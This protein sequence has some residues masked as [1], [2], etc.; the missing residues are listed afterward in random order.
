MAYKV[1][2][3]FWADGLKARNVDVK[4][5]EWEDRGT[6]GISGRFWLSG[7]LH[8][9]PKGYIWTMKTP[10]KVFL[11]VAEHAH[12]GTIVFNT[13]ND[14]GI[15]HMVE[16]AIS[17]YDMDTK[18]VKLLGKLDFV[19]YGDRRRASIDK[20]SGK[21][22]KATL[23]SAVRDLERLIAKAKHSGDFEY[24]LEVI[25]ADGTPRKSLMLL[26]GDEDSRYG[27]FY[28][29]HTRN[30]GGVP[31]FLLNNTW[32]P[33]QLHK[34]LEEEGLTIVGGKGKANLKKTPFHTHTQP[35]YSAAAVVKAHLNKG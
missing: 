17:D 11:N 13:E 21:L 34:V 7:V 14:K 26:I 1:K 4:D 30:S 9:Q 24:E 6:S 25:E 20:V 16:A 12:S 15:D 28:I 2:A 33:S 27:H 31:T 22:P 35:R 19:S 8:V 5:Y 18:V 10:F 32:K 23:Q 3:E 29:N